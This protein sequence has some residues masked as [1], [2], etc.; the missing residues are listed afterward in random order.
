MW[1]LFECDFQL[2]EETYICNSKIMVH[3]S[4]KKSTS[5]YHL[6]QPVKSVAEKD[7]CF[8]KIIASVN[9]GGF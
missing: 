6:S 3:S 5:T 1:K 4:E 7:F 2:H 9:K 8:P